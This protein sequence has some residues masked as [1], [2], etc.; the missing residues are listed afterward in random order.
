MIDEY[1]TYIGTPSG[2][3]TTTT[4]LSDVAIDN[5]TTNASGG[6]DDKQANFGGAI[7]IGVEGR[8]TL[9]TLC[10]VSQV[11][12]SYKTATSGSAAG[13]TAGWKIYAGDAG[14]TYTLI[15]S[16]TASLTANETKVFNGSVSNVKYIKVQIEYVRPTASPQLSLNL[17][18][19][20]TTFTVPIDGDAQTEWDYSGIAITASQASGEWDFNI[21][22]DS[23]RG[24]F[25]AD[26]D[27]ENGVVVATESAISPLDATQAVITTTDATQGRVGPA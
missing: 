4:R 13:T 1:R 22:I 27:A 17:T 18:D 3:W 15:A 10:L 12:M 9:D 14:E 21:E 26:C 20:R 25:P 8:R 16:N 5:F 19:L 24:T 2:A 11:R 6:T 23:I 7:T